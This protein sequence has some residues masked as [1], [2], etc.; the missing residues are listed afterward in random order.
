MHTGIY[1]FSKLREYFAFVQFL[2]NWTSILVFVFYI[3]LIK[4]A[5]RPCECI[6]L[7]NLV[8]NSRRNLPV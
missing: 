4:D 5:P 1:Y 3:G 2:I 7:K 8:E 6:S